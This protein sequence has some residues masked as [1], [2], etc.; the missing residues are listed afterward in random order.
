MSVFVHFNRLTVFWQGSIVGEFRNFVIPEGIERVGIATTPLG[1]RLKAG[2]VQRWPPPPPPSTG[3]VEGCCGMLITDHPVNRVSCTWDIALPGRFVP[4]C[5]MPFWQRAGPRGS[6]RLP[7]ATSLLP[8]RTTVLNRPFS[9]NSSQC[10]RGSSM[11]N[12][13][14]HF[15]RVKKMTG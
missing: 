11:L 8:W 15:L 9:G 1:S 3:R 10:H 6:D 5:Q 7:W 13:Y 14:S 2:V 12:T 4:P